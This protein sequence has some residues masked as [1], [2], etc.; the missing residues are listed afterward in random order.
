MHL[1]ESRYRQTSLYWALPYYASQMLRFLQIDGLWQLCLEEDHGHDFSNSIRSL[2]VSESHF[3]H[4]HNISDFSI[5]T[6]FVMV[7]CEQ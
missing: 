2:R 7:T 4:S 6:I 3:G 1:G 5:I